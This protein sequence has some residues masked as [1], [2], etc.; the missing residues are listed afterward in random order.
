MALTAKTAH[1]MAWV[2]PGIAIV[3]A[4]AV[5]IKPASQTAEQQEGNTTRGRQ[6]IAIAKEINAGRCYE[7]AIAPTKSEAINIDPKT[8][9]SSCIYGQ[10]WYGFMAQKRNEVLVVDVFSQKELNATLS[11]LKGK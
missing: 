11:N 8:L 7:L 4:A 1:I 2:C 6:M 9:R 10:G 3:I 5:T